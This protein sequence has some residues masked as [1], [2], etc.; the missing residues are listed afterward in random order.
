MREDVRNELKNLKKDEVRLLNKSELARRLGCNRRTVDKYLQEGVMS[1]RRK[2]REYE[3][4]LDD[5]KSIIIDK[6][7][8]Y[9]ATA[10]AVYKFI[11]KKGYSGGYGIVNNFVKKHKKEEL[12]KATIRFET[13]PGLQAQVDWKEKITMTN[14][15]GEEF[16]VN[17]F[18]MV[19]G[20]SR[21]KFIRITTD[22]VQK[23][24]FMCLFEAIKYYQ[25]VPH[26]ILFDN[27]STVVDRD[28]STF[29]S[30]SINQTFKHFS[31]DAGF[32]PIT[33]RPYRAQTKGKV[34][35]LAKFVDR[36][37]V[38]NGE[39]DSYED[40]E[41]ITNEFMEEINSE[42]S[43]ATGESPF[44]RFEKEKE[45]LGP[46]P[47]MFSLLSYFSYHKEYKV[48]KE[49]MVT[50]KGRKYSV[51]VKYI[52]YH[53]NII[54]DVDDIRIYYIEDLIECHPK[55]DKVLNYKHDHVAEILKTDALK[56][57]SDSEIDTFIK[58]N[59]NHMDILLK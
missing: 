36:L 7:D 28:K 18:L 5:Y 12:H 26:E 23:T 29:K 24:L 53:V 6:V 22:R 11:Q 1:S 20:Y 16:I 21:L 15:K 19:L 14:K 35:A 43:Q 52:G 42:I 59:L 40:L 34:E 47:S 54:E 55:R 39:F 56:H 57:L 8:T 51:P 49:S 46:L 4:K 13:A 45:Y 48:S 9:G 2:K 32:T 44:E 31:Q 58:E 37:K 30:V 33:C 27:M 50:Y 38:Y 3:S 25:G 17:I 10:M 41:K